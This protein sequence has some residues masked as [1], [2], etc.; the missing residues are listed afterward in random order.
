M[1]SDRQR[2]SVTVWLMLVPLLVVVLGGLSVDLWAGLSTRSRLAAIADDA[3]AAGATAVSVPAVRQPDQRVLLDT[4]EAVRRATAAVDEHPEVGLVTGRRA[5]ADAQL[6]T[7]VVEGRHD[8]LLLGLLGTGS[9]PVLVRGH[10]A[11]QGSS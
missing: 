10:A 1:S 9:T 6:V 7:V 2:G 4:D 8:F 3:A 5:T 11:P